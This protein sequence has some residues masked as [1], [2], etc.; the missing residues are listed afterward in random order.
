MA[1]AMPNMSVERMQFWIER[2][3]QL[4]TLLAEMSTSEQLKYIYETPTTIELKG[5]TFD[6]I[7]FLLS[8]KRVCIYENLNDVLSL[9]PKT[10]VSGQRRRIRYTHTKKAAYNSD[11]RHDLPEQHVFEWRSI[12]LF[13][14]AAEM[15]KYHF[16]YGHAMGLSPSTPNIL[17]E[18]SDTFGV[19]VLVIQ[20]GKLPDD[21][22]QLK[23]VFYNDTETVW[24]AGTRVF[25]LD[26]TE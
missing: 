26:S 14:T 22:W 15:L 24:P 20:K 11:I 8:D 1:M 5:E 13:Y 3:T 10:L 6:P 23:V 19:S 4:K 16:D 9:W 18:N 12:D 2:P 17:Y 21:P 7:E 25:F